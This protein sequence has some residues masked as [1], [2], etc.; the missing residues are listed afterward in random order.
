[1]VLLLFY[2]ILREGSNIIKTISSNSYSTN[3]YI[4]EK[5]NHIILVD[6]I[7]EVE[8]HLANKKIDKIL[9]THIHFDHIALLSS[10]Q[11][12]FDFELVLSDF[13]YKNINNPRYNLLEHI[14]SYMDFEN[15]DVDLKNAKIVND[16]DIIEWEGYK[17]KAISTPGHSECSMCYFLEEENLLFSGDTLFAG[18]YGRTDLPSGDNEKIFVSINRL[19][20]ILKDD[21]IVYP[22]H[23]KST[24]IGREKENFRFY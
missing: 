15:I 2:W 9:L 4:I 7:P 24:T 19:F 6:F 12:H 20:E 11:K 22:G 16:G 18:T 8:K 1:L 3:C 13:A 5:N 10:F 14:S 17:I 21:V 23:E